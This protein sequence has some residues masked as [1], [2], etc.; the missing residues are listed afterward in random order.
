[1]NVIISRRRVLSL[2]PF[3]NAPASEASTTTLMLIFSGRKV[4][5]SIDGVSEVLQTELENGKLWAS[6]AAPVSRGDEGSVAQKVGLNSIN[7]WVKFS[8]S[9]VF[10]P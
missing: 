10:D 3:M 7:D 2:L 5:E 6:E 8:T 1:M 9:V 4:A